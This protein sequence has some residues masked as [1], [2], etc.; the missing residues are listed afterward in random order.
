MGLSPN[1][2]TF[3]YVQNGDPLGAWTII[4]DAPSGVPTLGTP[5]DA[6]SI[7]VNEGAEVLHIGDSLSTGGVSQ[8]FATEVGSKYLLDFDG[9]GW[10]GNAATVHV[11]V[12]D[13]VTDVATGENGAEWTT[14]SLM[15]SATDATSTL[16]LQ[17]VE[18]G[19]ATI[20]DVS[21]RLVPEPTS[22]ALLGCSILGLRALRRRRTA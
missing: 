3:A 22:V 4:G 7:P 8:S 19:G 11:E 17:N 9:I 5:Y 16:L 6:G 21:V 13:L 10:A 18:G 20:D 2:N 15:F 14:H 1:A 12:G